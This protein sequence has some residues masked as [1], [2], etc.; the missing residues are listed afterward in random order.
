ML[1]S[2]IPVL[3]ILIGFI[4]IVWDYHRYK[5]TLNMF[6]QS[7][8]RSFALY[9]ADT[10]TFTQVTKTEI[11]D[12]TGSPLLVTVEEYPT[13]DQTVK[14]INRRNHFEYT[15]M[16]RLVGLDNEASQYANKFGWLV[17]ITFLDGEIRFLNTPAFL[18]GTELDTNNTNVRQIQLKPDRATGKTLEVI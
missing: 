6:N 17:L 7:G 18:Q 4:G 5:L 8:I 13:L 15:F 3:L 12:V 1:I 9:S 14:L 10:T 2:M 16:F 11:T